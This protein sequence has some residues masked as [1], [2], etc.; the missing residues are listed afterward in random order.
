MAIAKVADA[1][2][3]ITVHAFQ[4]DGVT[5]AGISQGPFPLPANGYTA[6]FADYFIAGL[7]E[8]FTGVL[9]INAST[10]FA[11]L[12]LR[13]LVNEQDEFLMTTFPIADANQPA[14]SP[15]VFPQIADGGG[16][17][18]QFILISHAEAFNTTLSF[19]SEDGMPLAIGE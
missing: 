5:T 4:K 12:T 13:S 6:G 1:D 11:A 15:I 19:Y 14:P 16:Y 7:P 9:D 2:A 3:S 8:G 18:T 10:P 17:A